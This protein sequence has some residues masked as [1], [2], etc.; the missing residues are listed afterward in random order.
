M[1]KKN[2]RRRIF[3]DGRSINIFYILKF[4]NPTHV[5]SVKTIEYFMFIKMQR[6]YQ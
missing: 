5:D 4:L 3:K 6:Y 2:Q 1:F